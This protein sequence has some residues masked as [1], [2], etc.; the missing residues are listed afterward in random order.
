VSPNLCTSPLTT[1]SENSK[2]SLQQW[3]YSPLA[4]K[5]KQASAECI[6]TPALTG[7]VAEAK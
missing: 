4:A 7:G 6:I 3:N 2:H 1:Y 5:R